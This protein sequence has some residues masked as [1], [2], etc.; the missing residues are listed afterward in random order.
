VQPFVVEEANRLGLVCYDMQLGKLY[1]P[2]EPSAA[3]GPGGI[4]AT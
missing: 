1:Q 2:A 4:P 3:P